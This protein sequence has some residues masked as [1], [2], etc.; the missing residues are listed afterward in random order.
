MII[1][2]N[3]KLKYAAAVSVGLTFTV[4]MTFLGQIYG[5]RMMFSGSSLWFHGLIPLLAMTEF[6]FCNKTP[7]SSKDNFWAV[8]PMLA[9]GIVYVG[10]I[11]INGIK[12]N[13]WYGFIRWGYGVGAVIFMVILG[14]TY[15]IG[16]LLRK[17]NKTVKR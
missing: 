16:F 5:Y 10:N 13:D 11:F 7:M 9:Y 14:I 3:E 12:G 2:P 4:V 1:K 6:I 8:V 17:L 15:L